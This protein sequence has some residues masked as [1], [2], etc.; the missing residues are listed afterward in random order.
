MVGFCRVET[1]ARLDPGDDRLAEDACLV[2]LV[3]IGLGNARLFRRGR[4]DRRAVLGAA[5]GSLAVQLGRIVGDGKIDL[6][7]MTEADL[8]RIEHHL[9][10]L[11]MAR[12]TAAD[13]LVFRR[14]LRTAG[15]AGD[16][17]DHTVDMLKDALHAPEA[18]AGK[19]DRFRSRARR[20]I[21]G[22]LRDSAG[23]TG[24][25]RREMQHGAADQEHGDRCTGTPAVMG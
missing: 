24:L 9:D 4:E 20:L 8:V 12:R 5:I 17:A 15:I 18:T 14:V 7:Q 21:D 6:Q 25:R 1:L 3:D 13:G 11:G 16:R 19:R 23:F 22:G 2:Q 10:R